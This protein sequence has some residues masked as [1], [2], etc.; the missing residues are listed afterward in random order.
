MAALGVRSGRKVDARTSNEAPP[1]HEQL[2][3]RLRR[4]KRVRVR[5]PGIPSRG[6]DDFAWPEAGADDEDVPIGGPVDDRTD[7]A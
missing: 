4:R 1:M 3:A 7:G 6:F 2:D 5:R